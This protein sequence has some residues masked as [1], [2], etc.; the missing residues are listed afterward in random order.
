MAKNSYIGKISIVIFLTVLIWVWA[1]LA[2][3]EELALSNVATLSVAKSSDPTLWLSFEGADTSLQSSVTLANIELKGSASRV[4]DVDRMRNRGELDVALFLVPEQEGFTET[5]TRTLDMFNFLR[6]SDTIRQLGLTVENCEP[7]TLTVHIRQLVEKSLPVECVDEDGRQLKAEVEPSSVS[8]FVPPDEV[9][10]ATVSLLSAEQSVART[11]AIQKTPY[12]ELA[13]GQQRDATTKVTV[14]LPAV[15]AL[16]D[17][18]VSGTYG[19]CFSP[20]LQGKFRVELEGNPA[21]LANVLIKATPPAYQAYADAPYQVILYIHDEDR[22]AT[23]VIRRPVVFSFP[24]E[25][26]RRDEIKP[27]QS[28]LEARFRLLPIPVPAEAVPG[29]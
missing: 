6:Q 22:Q 20:N 29:S 23:E 27:D 26:V 21:D 12:V 2:Q 13:P 9:L 16:K 14:T 24:E 4:R 15:D 25:Y 3:D 1:D 5:G 8:M 19:F 28:P 17:Y 11:T 10:V 7:K 18:Q